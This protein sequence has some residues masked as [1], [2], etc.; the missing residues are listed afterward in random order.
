MRDEILA[1]LANGEFV[2]GEMM[3]R[4]FSV[5][6]A[7]IAKHIK[8]LRSQGYEIEALPNRGYR[9]KNAPDLLSPARIKSFFAQPEK[10]LPWQIK[11]FSELESTNTYL[12]QIADQDGG[13]FL[14]A[15]AEH[16]TAGK[17][18]LG[19]A[20]YS[21]DAGGLWMSLLIRPQLSPAQAQMLTLG[22]AVAVAKAIR[23]MDIAASIKWPNDV[24]LSDGK[25]VCG[26]RCEMRA[27]IE[28]V[29]WVVIG[30][31]I[32]INNDHFPAE[33]AEIAT[34]LKTCN[35]G[36]SLDRA[37]VAA[38]VLQQMSDIYQKLERSA[39]AEITQ[40]WQSLATGLH[41]A[42]T[43]QTTAGGLC[44]VMRGLDEE[45]YLLL[46]VEGQI[47]RVLAGD[48]TISV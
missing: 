33:L 13:N 24:L 29:D 30:I 48:M 25:K 1:M 34:C 32:N 20:W 12:R 23:E 21:P 16:Q 28:H 3:S 15:I 19:R 22:T 44:G 46:E 31:G 47:Q 18:R 41:K 43:I 14:V 39:F 35:H 7:A 27:D 4:S 6:R 9:L 40:D 11:V 38:A 26:I 17:G 42:V 10:V 8:V 36:Q 45:G 5:S 2:S 37:A